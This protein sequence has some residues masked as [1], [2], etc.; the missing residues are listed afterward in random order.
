MSK[1]LVTFVVPTFNKEKFISQTIQ[2]IQNQ[3]ISSWKL[4][5]VDDA[6]SDNTLQIV[7]EITDPRRTKI[8][9]HEENQGVCHVLN[10]ALKYVDTKY[11]VQIDGDDWIEPNLLEIMISEMEKQ[12]KTTALAYANT[13]LWMHRKERDYFKHVIKRLEFKSRYDFVTYGPMVQPRF[14]RTECVKEVGGWEIDDPSNG[15]LMED[16]RM[17][18]RLLDDYKFKYIDENLYNLRIHGNNLSSDKN[19]E[20]YNVIKKY[21]TDKALSRWGDGVKARYIGSPNTWKKIHLVKEIQTIKK[22]KD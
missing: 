14:Y 6:S 18:L 11:F 21:Y 22:K 15:R 2:S 19:A 16:R 12:S 10:T 5:I 13:N 9:K 7:K 4:I 17:L 1:A 8:I 20:K 3:T